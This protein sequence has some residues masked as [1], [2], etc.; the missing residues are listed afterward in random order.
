MYSEPM[1]VRYKHFPQPSHKIVEMP[2]P[3]EYIKACYDHTF[4]AQSVT[5]NVETLEITKA[6]YYFVALIANGSK[7]G[8][9]FKLLRSAKAFATYIEDH[10]YIGECSDQALHNHYKPIIMKWLNT[11][12]EGT[13]YSGSVYLT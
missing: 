9:Y 10:A 8:V 1:L 11:Y 13:D 6:Y 5:I 4:I 12:A 3:K 2:Y 7:I